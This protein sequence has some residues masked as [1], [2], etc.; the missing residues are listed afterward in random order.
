MKKKKIFL[1]IVLLVLIGFSLFFLFNL[2]SRPEVSYELLEHDNDS[3]TIRVS[4]DDSSILKRHFNM[5]S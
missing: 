4:I 2:L 5:A 1:L 3:A